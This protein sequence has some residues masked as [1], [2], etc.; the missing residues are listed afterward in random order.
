MAG[1]TGPG[2]GTQLPRRGDAAPCGPCWE[3][4]E[5][6]PSHRS[7][8]P[9][10]SGRL[11]PGLRATGNKDM[12][13]KRLEHKQ[14]SNGS[15]RSPTPRRDT[16]H[17]LF[18]LR[19]TDVS[20]PLTRS[21]GPRPGG[22][23]PLPSGRQDSGHRPGSSSAGTGL[24]SLSQWSQQPGGHAPPCSAAGPTWKGTC[25]IPASLSAT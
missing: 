6:G 19:P 16:P 4:N 12:K 18:F 20:R 3:E 21:Q 8:A 15:T 9:L 2:V 11:C 24:L 10:R 7:V 13:C 5:R 25:L 22:S 23:T 17:M 14:P 1:E